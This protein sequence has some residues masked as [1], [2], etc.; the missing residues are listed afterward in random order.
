[1]SLKGHLRLS[2][3]TWIAGLVPSIF[4]ECRKVLTRILISWHKIFEGSTCKILVEYVEISGKC[5]DPSLLEG[6]LSLQPNGFIYTYCPNN[7]RSFRNIKSWY[8]VFNSADLQDDSE[9][10]GERGISIRD[11]DSSYIRLDDFPVYP[12]YSY[13]NCRRESLV[14]AMLN[15]KSASHGQ[16]LRAEGIDS[17]YSATSFRSLDETFIHSLDSFLSKLI[18]SEPQIYPVSS[19][20]ARTY[21]SGG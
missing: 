2:D 6:F 21:P 5:K 13:K 10:R 14:V 19:H 9:P 16:F 18:Y 1:M 4:A 20:A 15:D 11:E 17:D 3:A 8:S 7:K 12:H